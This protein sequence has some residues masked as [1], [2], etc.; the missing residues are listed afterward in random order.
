[1]PEQFF[2]EDDE[3]VTI[4]DRRVPV[5]LCLDTS[6]SMAKNDA[7]DQL[8]KGVA[9]FIDYIRTNDKTANS[10][11]LAIVSFDSDIKVERDFALVD[12]NCA[13]TLTAQ[14]GTGLAHGVNKALDIL[15]E[16]KQSYKAAGRDYF[17]PLLVIFTDGKPGDMEDVPAAQQRCQELIGGKKLTCFAISVGN[18]E[19]LEKVK[20]IESFLKGFSNRVFH[21]NDL[22]FEEFFEW[23][24][25]SME[26]ISQSKPGEKVNLPKP[27]DDIFSIIS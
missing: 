15:D 20:N 24:A 10:V 23:L 27:E 16:R 26:V 7:I 9:A 3:L 14:G 25:A 22:K 21:I 1:M 6:G 17:Q 19:D 13:V 4:T 12:E 5:C 8:N 18:D 11:E 2:G